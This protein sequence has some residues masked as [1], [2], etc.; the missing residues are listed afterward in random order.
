MS[1]ERYNAF[2]Q[3]IVDENE[4]V[5]SHFQENPLL[6]HNMRVADVISTVLT[7]DYCRANREHWECL[8]ITSN[9][10]RQ[11]FTIAYV[12][13]EALDAIL[14][15]FMEDFK[16]TIPPHILHY[17]AAEYLE[18][19][20]PDYL[21]GRGSPPPPSTGSMGSTDEGIGPDPHHI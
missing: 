20:V 1:P 12:K 17:E 13:P 10:V 5:H 11:I 4:V 7:F 15:E 21:V 6:S 2:I 3:R 18:Y 16:E 19:P 8:A 14:T 9:V